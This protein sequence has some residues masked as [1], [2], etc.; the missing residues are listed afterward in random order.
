[1][2]SLFTTSTS[3]VENSVAILPKLTNRKTIYYSAASFGYV[4]KRSVQHLEEMCNP[5]GH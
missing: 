3:V 2:E 4:S 5:N 1:M